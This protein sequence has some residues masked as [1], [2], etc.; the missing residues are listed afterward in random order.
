[1]A[2]KKGGGTEKARKAPRSETKPLTIYPGPK[3]TAKVQVKKAV[4]TVNR[5]VGTKVVRVAKKRRNAQVIVRSTTPGQR[6]FGITG[7]SNVPSNPR[8][9]QRK[10]E[11]FY[12]G[13][14]KEPFEYRG[15]IYQPVKVKQ[16][17]RVYT[18]TTAKPKQEVRTLA[19]ELGHELGLEHP[20]RPRRRNL[21]TQSNEAGLGGVRLGSKQRATVL[22]NRVPQPKKKKTPIRKKP[23]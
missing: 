8:E 18:T 13:N 2:G 19:H 1:M 6:A 16:R 4:R 10:Q 5:A 17:R 7:A 20:A 3:V 23:A 9:G 12:L 22:A 14:K 21:M 15:K 11:K